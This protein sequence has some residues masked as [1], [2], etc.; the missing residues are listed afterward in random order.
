VLGLLSRILYSRK[1]REDNYV[2]LLFV[3]K[4]ICRYLSLAETLSA[5]RFGTNNVMGEFWTVAKTV[6]LNGIPETCCTSVLSFR[7]G[8][9]KLKVNLC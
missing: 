7:K 5:K 1:Q 8:E 2:Y 6:G 4:V 9:H 3:Y